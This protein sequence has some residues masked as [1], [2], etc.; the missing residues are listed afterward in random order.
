M[1]G[2][3]IFFTGFPGFIG[4]RLVRKMM[5]KLDCECEFVLLV[6]DEFVPQAMR[7]VERIKREL[8][9]DD[10]SGSCKEHRMEVVAGDITASYLG[11]GEDRYKELVEKITD[12]F[13]LAAIYDLAVPES[14]ARKV[15]VEGTGNI[16]EFCKQC[17]N[18]KKF[19]Y[20]STC[21]VAGKRTG[22]VYEDELEMG[23]SFKNHYEATKYEAEVIVRRNMDEIPTIIV[24]PSIVVGDS[25]TG[26]TDKFDGPYFGIILVDRLKL[27][28]FPLPYLGKSLARV[29]LVPVDFVEDAAVAIWLKEA[30]EGKTYALADPEPVTARK[31]YSEIIRLLGARGPA[32]RIPPALVDIPLRSYPVRKLLGIPRQVLDYFNHDVHFDSRNT[33]EALKGSSIKCPN[34]FS[35]FPMIVEFYKNNKHRKELFWK[36]F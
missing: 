1:D 8:K 16:V 29:N 26:E 33:Q 35:Y 6:L 9:K 32:G 5:L 34:L 7:E 12:V 14:R 3:K 19:V 15:N 13:H 24:R 31:L 27:F 2:R 21:Y 28:R 23:Q 30:T 20:F 22:I 11:L 17:K 4:K 25:K 18:L 36:V 10:R